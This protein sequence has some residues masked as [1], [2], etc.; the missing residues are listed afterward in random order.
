[1]N[2]LDI[3]RTKLAAIT[4]DAKAIEASAA[5]AGRAE[6]TTEETTK[7]GELHAAFQSTEAQIALHERNAQIEASAS[8]P[9]PTK[10]QPAP[11]GT[12]SISALPAYG[13]ASRTQAVSATH[14][15]QGF[16]RGLGEFFGAVK[17]AAMGRVDQH[18]SANRLIDS[19]GL[20]SENVG[21]EGGLGSVPGQG[22][23]I[24]C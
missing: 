19:P 9:Q 13:T 1:M 10:T 6:F 5:A 4:A 17:M 2:P 11:A 24:E 18:S 15:N 8:V 7:L 12:P 21:H 22:H 23:D 14:G 20:R 16:A 3:L